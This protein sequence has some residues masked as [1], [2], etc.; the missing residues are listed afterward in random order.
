MR[1]GQRIIKSCTIKPDKAKTYPIK[2]RSNKVVV[3]DFA[4][5][6][7]SGSDFKSFIDSLPKILAGNDFRGVVR[8][9]VTAYKNGKPIIFAMG[10][11]AIKCGLSPLIIDL[12]KRRLITAIA[13][14]R[15]GSIHDF[16]IALIGATSE[17]VD[18]TIKDGNFGMAEDTG[19]LMNEAIQDGAERNLGM[20]LALGR[21]L[22]DDLGRG[23]YVELDVFG[24]WRPLKENLSWYTISRTPPFLGEHTLFINK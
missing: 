17:D 4:R 12:M 19:R 11:H 22:L 7:T 16:E 15:A 13:T 5:A 23:S 24:L 20:G 9:I 2:L 8:A 14:N 21:K 3:G 6:C 1:T 10:G 18:R